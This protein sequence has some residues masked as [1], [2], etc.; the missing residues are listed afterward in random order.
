MAV[1]SSLVLMESF[2]SNVLYILI[3]VLLIY[4]RSKKLYQNLFNKI[5]LKT[6]LLTMAVI[7]SLVLM[8]SFFSCAQIQRHSSGS[9]CMER[10][11]VP[12]LSSPTPPY[13]ADLNKKNVSE[14]VQQKSSPTPLQPKDLNITKCSTISEDKS[15]K[16][17]VQEK[18]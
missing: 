3:Y 8:E 13:P 17:L 11:Q 9:V 5:A 2:F 14:L 7:S 12:L 16:Q 6:I 4:F 10:V 15:I 1:I 18:Y